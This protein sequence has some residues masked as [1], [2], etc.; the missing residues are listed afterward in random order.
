VCEQWFLPLLNNGEELCFE[1]CGC[2]L[3]AEAAVFWRLF[4]HCSRLIAIDR[5]VQNSSSEGVCRKMGDGKVE[6][7]NQIL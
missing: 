2:L 5:N 3:S 7:G 4:S 6:V 1:G